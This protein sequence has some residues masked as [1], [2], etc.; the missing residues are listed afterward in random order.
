MDLVA[1]AFAVLLT[2]GWMGYAPRGR[3]R[4]DKCPWCGSDERIERD[5]TYEDPWQWCR[6]CGARWRQP[7][8]WPDEE[9]D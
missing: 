6:C 1:V 3:S 8:C 9:E 2:I 4:L 7:E 5:G